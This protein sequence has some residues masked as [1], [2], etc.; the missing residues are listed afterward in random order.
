[1]K[2]K[3]TFF[4]VLVIASLVLVGCGSAEPV[5][6]TPHPGEALVTAKCGTCHGMAQVNNVK[7]TRETWELTVNRM[8]LAGMTITDQDREHV[9]DYLALRDAE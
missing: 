9:I 4:V 1:M 2:L 7:Y 8:V 3:Y 6:P 5:A